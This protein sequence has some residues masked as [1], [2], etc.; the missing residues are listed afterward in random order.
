MK[1]S[2]V[3]VFLGVAVALA[4][5]GESAT[6]PVSAGTGR[7]PRLPRRTRRSCRPS[8][9]PPRRAGAT[10]R[11]RSA[12]NGVTVSAY[13]TGLD[14]PRWLYVLPNGDVL[15]AETNAPPKPDDNKGIRG[16][17]MKQAM[18]RAGAGTPSANRITLLRGLRDDGTAE[19]KTVF[20][21]NLNSPFGMALVGNDFYVANTDAVVRYAYTPDRRGSKARARSWSTCPRARSITTG[22][23]A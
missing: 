14:H 3:L 21:E 17:F 6:L 9:S 1:N 7:A 12:G 19:L 16:F 23:R 5:C 18:K 22:P 13:A 11:V 8:T 4:G 15:V 20:L 10:A 2:L